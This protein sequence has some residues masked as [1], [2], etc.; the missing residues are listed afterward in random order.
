[1]PVVNG[2]NRVFLAFS[3]F[4]GDW[5]EIFRQEMQFAVELAVMTVILQDSC[6]SS[7]EN[8][9]ISLSVR[10]YPRV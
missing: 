6:R 7:L 5:G 8:Q 1:M 9:Q 4:F 3:G 2:F 10:D